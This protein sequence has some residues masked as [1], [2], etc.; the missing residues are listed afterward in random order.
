MGSKNPFRDRNKP[1]PFRPGDKVTPA[2][3]KRCYAK[4][5]YGEYRVVSDVV[6]DE[7]NGQPGSWVLVIFNPL[8][9]DLA[10][11]R[12]YSKYNPMNFC[13]EFP[14]GPSSPSAPWEPL[15]NCR[16]IIKEKEPMALAATYIGVRVTSPDDYASS[17]AP[18]YEVV[19]K[20][21]PNLAE[22]QQV[23]EADLNAGEEV[24]IFRAVMK[25]EG[26]PPRPPI[27]R[28]DFR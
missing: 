2:R 10:E 24:I 26:L 9:A 25:L 6:Y 22:I 7:E 17:E 8:K 4:W 27:R 28:T 1:P 5:Y 20:P 12:C 15:V 21:Y 14:P 13:G 23:I 11:P 19:T 3:G 18:K 16:C